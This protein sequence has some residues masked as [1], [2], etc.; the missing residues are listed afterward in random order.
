MLLQN[1]LQHGEKMYSLEHIPCER[2][3]SKV[4]AVSEDIELLKKE[5]KRWL[6]ED[7]DEECEYKNKLMNSEWEKYHGE[8]YWNDID[9]YYA[10]K[11]SK[12][13]KLE[14]KS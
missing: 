10:F 7:Y 13:K 11:I 8:Y 9:E 2:K 4:L 14:K 6:N 12:V 1:S 3:Y 5:A